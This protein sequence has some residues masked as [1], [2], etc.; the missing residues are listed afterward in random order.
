MCRY[1]A[2]YNIN[3]VGRARI[4]SKLLIGTYMLQ[5][6]R[7]KFNK[8]DVDPGPEDTEHFLV[9]CSSL[10]ETRDRF[11]P[12]IISHIEAPLRGHL[13]CDPA[14]LTHCILDS[15]YSGTEGFISENQFYQWE[16]DTRMF[17]YYL[18]VNIT[19]LLTATAEATQHR[20]GLHLYEGGNTS[21]VTSNNFNC[22]VF[23]MGVLDY[24]SR[25]P[26]K[27]IRRQRRC[28]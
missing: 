7:S 3:D 26:A 24:H 1:E 9:H 22:D 27:K 18:H 4:K 14:A 16:F 5:S 11:L 21:Q 25:R 12:T 20:N 23:P 13:A 8:L 28:I 10:Q 17:C 6:S 15:N 2:Q 19:K